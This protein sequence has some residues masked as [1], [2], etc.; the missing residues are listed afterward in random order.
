[1]YFFNNF[2]TMILRFYGGVDIPYGSSTTLPYIKQYFG[3]GAYSIRGWRPRALG[4]GSDLDPK[5][6]RDGLDNLFIDQAGDIKLEFNAEYRFTVA[7]LFANAISLN[8]ALFTDAG[9]IWLARRDQQLPNAEF[10]F[11]RLGQDIA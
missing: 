2:S 11:K 8:G 3:G 6:N 7:R 1:K 10:N 9:N 5:V 4:P